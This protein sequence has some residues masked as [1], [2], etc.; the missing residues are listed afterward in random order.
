VPLK[1]FV[2]QFP[3]ADLRRYADEFSY[4][5]SPA[6][7]IAT[8]Q[9]AAQA[10]RYTRDGVI[11]VVDW[12]SPR[13]KGRITAADGEIQA[14]T[15]NAL[16]AD[17]EQTRM[18]TLTALPGVGV[19]VASALLLFA[20]G[21]TYPILDV[22]ALA[23]LGHKRRGINPTEFWLRYLAFVRQLAEQNGITARAVEKAL[24]EYEKQRKA[25]C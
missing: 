22:N 3:A 25:Q 14:A 23:S 9:A 18:E 1:P 15:A 21:E 12:K 13:T 7:A 2:L 8:G 17:N 5:R 6:N 4:N 16:S 19:P 11:A 10:G 20:L 24:W